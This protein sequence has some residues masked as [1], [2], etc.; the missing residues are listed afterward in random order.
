MNKV[1]VILVAGMGTRLKPLT[2]R[3]HKCLTEVNGEPILING[4]K[5]LEKLGFEKAV[6]VI[7]YLGEQIRKRIGNQF[8]NMGIVYVENKLFS[9]TNTTYS[10]K[11]GLEETA[12]D[13]EVIV[14]EGDVFF[15]SAVLEE[16]LNTKEKNVTVLEAYNPNLEGTFVELDSMGY[17][18]DWTHKSERPSGYVLL[19]K[20]KTVN[21]HKFSRQFISVVLEPALNASVN[22]Y[23][24]KEPLE[25]V[26]M[27]IVRG[28]KK[29]IKG[30]IL[31]GQ[32]WFEIDDLDDLKMAEK[33]FDKC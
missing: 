21:I 27:R 10:L 32:K 33:I 28:S 16:L 1:A 25:N 31:N 2:L 20:Y 3:N 15:E 30:M 24:G 17:V 5:I 29:C 18:I 23:G 6:L 4:L 13:E 12:E 26:M 11:L 9:G 22:D 19:D 14:L 8:G 7:G